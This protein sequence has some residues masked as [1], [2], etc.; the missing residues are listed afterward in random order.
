M[1]TIKHG[2]VASASGGGLHAAHSMW[3]YCGAPSVLCK[4]YNLSVWRVLCPK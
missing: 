1:P 3:M 4:C 2:P